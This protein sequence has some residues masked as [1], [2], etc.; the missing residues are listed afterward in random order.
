MS[1]YRRLEWGSLARFHVLDTRQYRDDQM[2]TQCAP[3]E[4]DPLSSYCPVQLDPARSIL[5][6]AQRDW[7]FDGLAA[8]PAS[9][10]NV[11]ANQVGFAAQAYRPAPGLRGF[12]VDSWDGYAADRQGVLDFLKQC[13]LTNVVVITGDKHQNSVR[14]VAESYTD[15]A[16][17]PITTEFVGTSIS[18]G[19][20]TPPRTSHGD[21]PLN[22]H[23]LF[24]NFNRGY[25]RVEVDRDTWRSDFRIVET[26]TRR[27]N[28]AASTLESWVVENGKPGAIP[29]SAT[30][31]PEV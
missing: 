15:I 31:A 18:S 12:F 27:E 19:G 17:P 3:D 25:V 28:V 20:D 13:G 9:G 7:L 11:L 10:W 8:T 2:L 21:D 1:L 16:G 29:A 30:Q 22:P 24:E 5:G 4:R 26:V 23:V 14:N 6:A